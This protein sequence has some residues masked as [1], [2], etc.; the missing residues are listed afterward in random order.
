[1]DALDEKKGV[2]NIIKNV[3]GHPERNNGSTV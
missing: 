3:T 1:M 2:L